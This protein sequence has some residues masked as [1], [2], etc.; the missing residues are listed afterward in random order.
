MHLVAKLLVVLFGLAIGIQAKIRRP[1][2]ESCLYCIC[3][4]LN[5]CNATAVCV[6]GACGI[7]RINWN[8]WVDS[9]RLTIPGDSPLSYHA[10]T[11]CANDPICAAETVQS[12]MAK[13]GQDC[14]DDDKEDCYDYGAIHYKGPRNCQED[15]PY[16]YDRT[17]TCCVRKAVQLEEERQKFLSRF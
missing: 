14:N 10:F 3:E 15:L 7:F 16:F 5:G 9:G 1:V 17:F 8:R 13:F 12:Y 6:N 2:T 4:A 11:N